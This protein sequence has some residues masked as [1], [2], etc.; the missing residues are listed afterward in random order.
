LIEGLE[1]GP[2]AVLGFAA[3]LA[4]ELVPGQVV[5]SW[6]GIV[7]RPRSPLP[8]H[9]QRRKFRLARRAMGMKFTGLAVLTFLAAL[10]AGGARASGD[11]VFGFWLSENQRAVIEIVPCG[12]S[13]CGKT[14]WLQEPLNGDGQPKT[15]DNNTD[16]EL[17]G[18][19]LCGVELIS[20]F[21]NVKPG[22]WSG[23]A[24]YSPRDGKTYAASMELR[25]DDTLELRGY[26]LLPLFG[27]TQVWTREPGDRGGC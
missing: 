10:H 6:C 2:A 13:A 15:D 21:Q 14:V 16:E 22:A 24:V 18:R 12:E 5:K 8:S 7:K 26:L 27:Q 17:R 1:H 3:M 25:G 9:K 11:P 23:G 4:L 19:M 20:N